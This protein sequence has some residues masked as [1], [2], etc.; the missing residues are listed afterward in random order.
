M[1]PA[2]TSLGEIKY[3][4]A[5]RPEAET[6]DQTVQ[7]A[8][9]NVKS[10]A[11]GL[12]TQFWHDARF[13]EISKQLRCRDEDKSIMDRLVRE[14]SAKD[15]IVDAAEIGALKEKGKAINAK[16]KATTESIDR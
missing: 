13:E 9:E 10:C 2:I 5:G 15:P 14:I 4:F 3:I 16:F 6:Y 8:S 7:P 1:E 11:E 12:K